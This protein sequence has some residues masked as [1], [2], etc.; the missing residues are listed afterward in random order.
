MR[1][2]KRSQL[3]LSLTQEE[4]LQI[5][6]RNILLEEEKTD[7]VEEK[8]QLT[9][10]NKSLTEEKIR[11]EE[12]VNRLRAKLFKKNSEKYKTDQQLFDEAKATKE[13]RKRDKA[14]SVAN[15]GLAKNTNKID[16]Q[17]ERESKKTG[18]RKPIPE[19]YSR[20]DI[21]HDLKEEEKHCD[22]GCLLTRFGEEVSEQLG[23]IPAQIYVLR[24]KRQKYACKQCQENVKIA[25]VQ[26]Q[27]IAKCLAAPGLLAHAA[28]LKFDDHLPLYRQSETIIHLFWK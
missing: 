14:I 18:G 4:I 5:I 20:V 10:A 2:H 28:I 9:K 21:V 6:K 1:N 16:V 7:W 13:E 11:L 24:H 12:E 27:A 22:C 19:D 26:N 15:K 8:L 17:E 25:P 23:I 3:N